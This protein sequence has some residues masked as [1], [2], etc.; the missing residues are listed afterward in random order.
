MAAQNAAAQQAQFAKMVPAEQQR[1]AQGATQAALAQRMQAMNPQQR[2]A[3][4]QR[5][6]AASAAEAA[7]P[8][9]ANPNLRATANMTPAQQQQR[10]TPQQAAALQQ[11]TPQQR[12]QFAQQF[13]AQGPQQAQQAAPQGNAARAQAIYA[14]RV[15]RAPAAPTAAPRPLSPTT[16]VR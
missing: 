6:Q 11:M 10:F 5:V 2:A 15:Q 14:A 4:A 3:Y 9:V 7:R 12:A 1:Y 16:R 13:Q 8:V